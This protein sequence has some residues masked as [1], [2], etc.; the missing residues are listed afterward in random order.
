MARRTIGTERDEAMWERFHRRRLMLPAPYAPV[1]ESQRR[2]RPPG[3]EMRR[4]Q[5]RN[6]RR[7]LPFWLSAWTITIDDGAV[8]IPRNGYA[9]VSPTVYRRG[10]PVA[11]SGSVGVS[12]PS[13]AW[14]YLRRVRGSS[15]EHAAV[16]RPI[17]RGPLD[18][19]ATLRSVRA[20]Q[21]AA[22]V[23]ETSSKRAHLLT[24]C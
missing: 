11:D 18:S 22:N 17:C 9:R 2:G 15:V 7:L 21:I 16:P 23:A 19:E 24:C 6:D 3:I 12:H 1:N 8:R 14:K 4:P 20:T 5:R 13:I 10:E